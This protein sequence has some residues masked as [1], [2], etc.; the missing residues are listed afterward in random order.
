MEVWIEDYDFRAAESSRVIDL[1]EDDA[2]VEL[3]EED[4]VSSQAAEA[5]SN[6]ESGRQRYRQQSK[7]KRVEDWLASGQIWLLSFK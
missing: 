5:P 6:C 2:G 1:Q 3:R 7:T 4:Y